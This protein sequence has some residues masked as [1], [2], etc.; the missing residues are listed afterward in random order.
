MSER[1]KPTQSG[2]SPYSVK[3]KA[4]VVWSATIEHVVHVEAADA[5]DALRQ[6]WRDRRQ[7][8]EPLVPEGAEICDFRAEVN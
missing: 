8:I 4:G 6:V 3:L 1:S 2:L 5:D 7:H